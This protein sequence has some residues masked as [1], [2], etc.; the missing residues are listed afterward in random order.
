MRRFLLFAII[1]GLSAL[2]LW[3][4]NSENTPSTPNQHAL[5][6]T[7]APQPRQVSEHDW[8]KRSIDRAREVA[9]EARK[10]TKDAQN[11]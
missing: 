9:E 1:A 7:P 2:Y 6:A 5:T 4:K 10:R 8:A 11:P 3:Q